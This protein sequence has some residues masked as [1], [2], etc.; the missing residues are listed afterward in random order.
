LKELGE[1]VLPA[2]V[3]L[4]HGRRS[5]E[6]GGSRRINRRQKERRSL[7]TSRYWMLNVDEIRRDRNRSSGGLTVEIFAKEKNGLNAGY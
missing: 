7:G 3:F 4:G 6:V 5:G 1:I 2:P